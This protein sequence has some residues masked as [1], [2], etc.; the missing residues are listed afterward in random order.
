MKHIK[1]YEEFVNESIND[2]DYNKILD[3]LK[4][5]EKEIKDALYKGADHGYWKL[6]VLP[7]YDN[8][9]G[10]YNIQAIAVDVFG[11][12]TVIE[13]FDTKATISKV[14]A[15]PFVSKVMV[16]RAYNKKYLTV[17]AI[18]LKN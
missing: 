6:E 10:G 9:I 11:R 1:L 18:G 12:N 5:H 8:V 3:V 17:I 15:L 13:S 7:K 16:S 4:T 2:E 14:K